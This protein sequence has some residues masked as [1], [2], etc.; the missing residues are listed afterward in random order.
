[1]IQIFVYLSN[2]TLIPEQ[3]GLCPPFIL[4]AIYYQ[5]LLPYPNPTAVSR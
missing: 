3:A 1:M 5:I 2:L 4:Y